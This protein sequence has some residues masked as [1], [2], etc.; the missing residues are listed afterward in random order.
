MGGCGVRDPLTIVSQQYPPVQTASC[1]N[2]LPASLN[3]LYQTGTPCYV[4]SEGLVRMLNRGLGNTWIPVCNM[5]E[6]CKAKSDHYW[7]VGIHENP[8]QL[9]SDSSQGNP[10]FA[11]VFHY[12]TRPAKR[13]WKQ[14]LKEATKHAQQRIEFINVTVCVNV[15]SLHWF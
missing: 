6:H 4:D 14:L 8:Q 10:L 5:R 2:E 12:R 15:S 7:V 13:N 11:L 9:R 3:C 1:C